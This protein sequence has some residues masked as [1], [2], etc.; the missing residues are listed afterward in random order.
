MPSFC[1]FESPDPFQTKKILENDSAPMKQKMHLFS[2]GDRLVTLALNLS[3]ASH[4]GG[5]HLESLTGGR[6]ARAHG[7]RWQRERFRD[8]FFRF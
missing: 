3:S 2:L 8:P 6:R 5:A 4:T 1:F 7:A